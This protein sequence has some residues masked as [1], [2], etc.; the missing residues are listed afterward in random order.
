MD[1][2]NRLRAVKETGL[3]GGGKKGEGLGKNTQTQMTVW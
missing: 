1:T 3:G 2:E